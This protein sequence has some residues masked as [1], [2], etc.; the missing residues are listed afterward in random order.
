MN[1]GAPAHPAG[2]GATAHG[3]VGAMSM[4]VTADMDV[5]GYVDRHAFSTL[6]DACSPL[7]RLVERP[8]YLT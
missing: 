1:G 8:H 2:G 3:V 5:V 7:V 4:A 6:D